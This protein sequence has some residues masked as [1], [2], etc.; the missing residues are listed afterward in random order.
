MFYGVHSID[1][2]CKTRLCMALYFSELLKSGPLLKTEK[3]LAT[4]ETQ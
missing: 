3:L 1:Y 2:Q 4:K